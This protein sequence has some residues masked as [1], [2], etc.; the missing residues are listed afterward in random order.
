MWYVVWQMPILKTIIEQTLATLYGEEAYKIVEKLTDAGFD[1]WWVG[2][3]VRDMLRGILPKDI[4]IATAATPDEIMHIFPKAT[5]TP[6]SL[7]SMRI[8]TGGYEFEVTTFREDDEKSDGRY[9]D[10]ITF[11]TRENDGKRR[12]FTV[13]ALYFN[14]INSAL[15]DPFAG[16]EDLIEGLIRFIGEPGI[17]IKH[18]ALRLLRPVR[19]R[20]LLN[21]QYHPG[22]IPSAKGTRTTC[23][24]TFG[25]QAI[26]GNGKNAFGTS[27]GK[28]TGRSVGIGPAGAISA[29]ASCM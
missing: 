3:C 20:A 5:P 8:G 12:D 16:E 15:Y 13:N 1:T 21:G 17:R 2:G 24:N 23:G 26:G 29:G 22:N 14:P 9:P 18:D 6:K 25:H 10:A 28:S 27:S 11:S 7:G 4:D 19:F